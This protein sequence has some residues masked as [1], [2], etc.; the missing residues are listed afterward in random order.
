MAGFC[1]IMKEEQNFQNQKFML[2]DYLLSLLDDANNFSCDAT[3]ASHA[4]LLCRM[5]QGEVV[6]YEENEKKLM[7]LGG[8][9]HRDTLHKVSKV[10]NL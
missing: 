4:V 2:F 3:K 5:E 9:M 8:L 1:C 10:L 6:S 7:A